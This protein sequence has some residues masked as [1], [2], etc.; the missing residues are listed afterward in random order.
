MK[1]IVFFTFLF[2]FL[3]I[4]LTFLN[5]KI[6]VIETK[7]I[8]TEIVNKKLEKD[9]VFF[10]SEWEYVNSPENISYLSKQHLQNKPAVLIEF[11]HFIKLLSNERHTNE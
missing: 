10:K 1:K 6:E 2:S 9:L 7:I 5:Y 11:Q 8:D 3:L 4:L